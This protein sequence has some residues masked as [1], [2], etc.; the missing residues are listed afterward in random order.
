MVCK[1]N[2]AKCVRFFVHLCSDVLLEVLQWAN[3]REIV[4]LEKVGRHFHWIA[5]S[6]FKNTPF[7]RL[8]LSLVP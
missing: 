5:E 4:K 8:N 7:L 6:Y 2:E 3:R 1:K